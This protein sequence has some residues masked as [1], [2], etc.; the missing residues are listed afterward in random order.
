MIGLFQ[1]GKIDIK[2][3][4]YKLSGKKEVTGT[5]TLT[6][7]APIEAKKLFMRVVA[8][9]EP[10]Q[11][12]DNRRTSGVTQ[13]LYQHVIEL[14]GPGIYKDKKIYTFNIPIPDQYRNKSPSKTIQSVIDVAHSFGALQANDIRWY[15]IGVLDKKWIN[16]SRSVEF[17]I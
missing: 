5:L 14:D 4:S 7:K 10:R 13:Q 16:I 1:K 15:V 12:L 3:D 9:R 2:L 11:Q 8:Q 6:C 17:G